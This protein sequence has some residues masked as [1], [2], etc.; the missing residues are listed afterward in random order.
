MF[1]GHQT[2]STRLHGTECAKG[3]WHFPETKTFGGSFRE[4][5]VVFVKTIFTHFSHFQFPSRK[6]DRLLH[7]NHFPFRPWTKRPNFNL[8]AK[9]NAGCRPSSNAIWRLWSRCTVAM[10]S[11]KFIRLL[12]NHIFKFH[13]NQRPPWKCI[14]LTERRWWTQQSDWM[15]NFLHG[16]AR[17][18]TRS[19][20]KLMKLPQ[21][22]TPVMTR[23]VWKETKK[24]G[25]LIS[26]IATHFFD[27]RE[28][29][30]IF[31]IFDIFNEIF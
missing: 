10:W 28:S 17:Q 9:E 26:D 7:Q 19:W 22:Q 4:E 23:M 21:Q 27:Q 25:S 16:W 30:F 24:H 1:N 8:R 2:S 31:V 3:N 12:T 15:G 6:Y 5:E 14:A 13:Q 20:R 29:R 11:E 18:R